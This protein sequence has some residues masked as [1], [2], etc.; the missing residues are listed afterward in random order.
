[1]SEFRADLHCHT[2]CSDGSLRPVELVRLAVD[3]G[4][5]GLSIT[6]HDTIDAY[7][8]AIPLAKE[9]G[10]ELISGVEFS[11]MLEG[12]SV[13]ILAYSFPIQSP[14]IR[15]FCLQHHAR[16]TK[17]NSDMLAR[18]SDMGMPLADSD[19]QAVLP[20]DIPSDQKVIGRPHIAQAM[21]QKKYVA[22]IQEAFKKYLGEGK[23]CYVAGD[24]FTPSETIDIIHR[25]NGF[26][27]IAHPHLV[28][29]GN[30]ILKLLKM[31]FD[32]IECFYSRFKPADH[33]RWQKIAEKREWLI[34]GG[35]DFHGDIKPLVPLGCSWVSQKEFSPL[36]ERFLE[37]N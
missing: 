3:I 11:S 36:K 31:D 4:L 33:K 18:L 5:K 25:A 30:T 21:V 26:A 12:V 15:E 8:T 29:E 27:I 9:L 10:L 16:R 35:S 28:T 24:Y 2:T 34:T 17:R 20:Q 37:N 1:M 6:D 32:G 7:E 23:P 19:L 13:H 14:L 22:D